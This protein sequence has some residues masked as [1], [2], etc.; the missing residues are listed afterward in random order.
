[1]L[2]NSDQPSTSNGIKTSGDYKRLEWLDSL[3]GIAALLVVVFHVSRDNSNWA[4][5]VNLYGN[6]NLGTLAV[7]VFFYVSGYA[8]MLSTAKPITATRFLKKRFM[9][10]Y[11]PY[12][13]MILL[14]TTLSFMGYFGPESKSAIHEILD[15]NPFQY[16]IGTVIVQ[17]ANLN[18]TSPLEVDWTLSVELVFYL[19]FAMLLLLNLKS[20]ILLVY[21]ITVLLALEVSLLRY[22][23]FLLLGSLIYEYRYQKIRKWHLLICVVL[24][25]LSSLNYQNSNEANLRGFNSILLSLLVFFIFMTYPVIGRLQLFRTLGKISYSLYLVHIP[26]YRVLKYLNFPILIISSITMSIILAF[27]YYYYVENYYVQKSKSI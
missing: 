8:M 27:F 4:N 12:L 18:I 9:R 24:L 7:S 6:I 2:Q 26:I 5:I 14:A 22:I 3:R 23:P 15:N 20:F 19:Q 17:L 25:F 10:L 21:F 13:I 11:V 16:L 1:M